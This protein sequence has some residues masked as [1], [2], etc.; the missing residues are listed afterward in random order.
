MKN[1]SWL[2]LVDAVRAVRNARGVSDGAACTFL[3][4]AC[5]SGVERSRKRPWPE[6]PDEPPDPIYDH[7]SPPISKLDWYGASIDLEHG[8][9]ILASGEI[10]RAD[11]EINADDLRSW[12]GVEET[13]PEEVLRPTTV[14]RKRGPKPIKFE[15]AKRKMRD[16]IAACRSTEMQLRDMKEKTLAGTYGV[17]RDTARR[18][19]DAVLS[20]FGANSITDK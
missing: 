1:R 6:Q 7:W 9:L 2:N 3:C 15:A 14:M 4:Q 17:S 20:E 18:A 16:D 8:W 19:R 13:K 10:V 5:E 11:I 12:L